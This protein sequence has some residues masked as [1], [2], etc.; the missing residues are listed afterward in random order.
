MQTTYKQWQKNAQLIEALSNRSQED[1]AQTQLLSYQL[2]ELD[3]LGI[4]VD[5][6]PKLEAEFKS[7]N[8]ADE[9]VASVQSAL[10]H[11]GG[12]DEKNATAAMHQALTALNELPEKNARV[13]SI[14]ELLESASIQLDEA[15]SDLRA[16]SDE[17]EANPE[18]L[19]QVN[20][21]LG[22]LHA[23]ARKHKVKPNELAQVIAD[24]EAAAEPY[25]RTATP[26][27]RS[28]KP[29]TSNCASTI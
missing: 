25:R 4:A 1:S 13:T 17:F 27:S 19:E 6:V 8:H 15:V 18:R 2:A 22:L 16:F 14:I 20:T 5:E 9:T 24:S 7:L 28:W 3:E 11:C 12:D 29:P 23:I 26:N 21:R 10:T